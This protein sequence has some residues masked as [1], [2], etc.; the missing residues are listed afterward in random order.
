MASYTKLSLNDAD[1]I[2]KSYNLG[3]SLK[4]TPMTLGISN[5]NYMVETNG[6][7][8]VI[9]I[10]NSKTLDELNEE[11]EILNHLNN[12]NFNYSIYPLKKNDSKVIFHLGE[13][14][15]L[16]FPYIEG[17]I[18]DINQQNLKQVGSTLALL[19]KLPAKEL[20]PYEKVGFSYNT[21]KNY[22][23][24][25]PSAPADFKETFYKILNIPLIEQ[26][27]THWR[28]SL[29]HG[30][31]YYDNV[32]LGIDQQI[33]IFDFEQSGLGPSIFDLGICI[34]GS[35]LKNGNIDQN[36]YQS[37]LSG[38]LAVNPLVK[39]EK[40]CLNDCIKLGLLAI[41]LWRIKRFKIKKID[42]SKQDSYQELLKRASLFHQEFKYEL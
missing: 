27:K 12:Q 20:R 42:P 39:E 26:N 30:D 28:Q 18:I 29:I 14:F 34:S 6:G 7:K 32:I 4:L 31:L 8:W 2:L 1:L 38:Y 9:K 40:N 19:H 15:G 33:K 36:L 3:T 17:K 21:L 16:V 10:F 23:D 35:C 11:I 22:V 24:A 25:D 41:A 5:S 13:K 37:L